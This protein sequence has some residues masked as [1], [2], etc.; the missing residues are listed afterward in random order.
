MSIRVPTMVALDEVVELFPCSN[1]ACPSHASGQPGA[2]LKWA[3]GEE[4]RRV[5]C[6]FCYSESWAEPTQKRDANGNPE[7]VTV[8]DKQVPVLNSGEKS[9]T[10]VFIECVRGAGPV[11]L[12]RNANT[13]DLIEVLR[14][15]A[16]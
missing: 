11:E 5:P 10:G 12:R 16:S 4:K 8:K 2:I 13:Y 3:E 15:K 9:S 7:F 6:Q 1:P 14:P